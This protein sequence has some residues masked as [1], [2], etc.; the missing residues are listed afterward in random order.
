MKWIRKI[1]NDPVWSKVISFVIITLVTAIYVK[2]KSLNQGKTFDQAFNEMLQLK[3]NLFTILVGLFLV[4]IVYIIYR[5]VIFKYSESTKKSD[6]DFFNKVRNEYLDQDSTIRFLRDHNFRG[7]F[8]LHKIDDIEKFNDK[9]RNSDFKF[10]N[11]RLEK[12][13]IQIEAQIDILLEIY[14]NKNISDK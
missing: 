14:C 8:N 7:P 2:I 3:V 10:I 5:M 1:W 9:C 13:K 6:L 11:P 4:L 12:L